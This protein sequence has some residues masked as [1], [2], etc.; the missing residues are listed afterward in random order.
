M[1]T[2]S[3]DSRSHALGEDDGF[4]AV[5]N[6][7]STLSD[8]AELLSQF[9]VPLYTN[10][11]RGW[12]EL[13]GSGFFVNSGGNNFLVSAA[14]VLDTCREA[15]V[16]YY[17][18]KSEVRSLSG[19]FMLTPRIGGRDNDPIDI[20]I[21]LL[22]SQ[23]TL[24]CFHGQ[25]N[26]LPSSYLSVPEPSAEKES[27][28]LAL[29]FPATRSIV[30]TNSLTVETKPQAFLSSPSPKN[31]TTALDDEHLVLVFDRK[32]S[33]DSFGH[34]KVFPDPHGMSGSPVFLM[35]S[36]QDSQDKKQEKLKFFVC[37][38]VIS[39][40]PQKHQMICVRSDLILKQVASFS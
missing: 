28:F 16:Y 14:H 7:S 11:N 34:H 6:F 17:C 31:T 12:P 36:P 10:D 1:R 40:N 25:K 24:P 30:N 35:Y 9:V 29:G 26:A 13:L 38:M 3:L 21:V 39:H 33:V 22:D 8:A 32:R 37:G 5:S 20:G 2:N 19:R 27:Q 23:H 18:S 4:S 15:S